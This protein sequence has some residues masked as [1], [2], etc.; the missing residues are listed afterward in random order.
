MHDDI[1]TDADLYRV[2]ASNDAIGRV[3]FLAL[4]VEAQL[5]HFLTDYFVTAERRE[6]FECLIQDR[7]TFFQKTEV[8]AGIDVLRKSSSHRRLIDCLRSIRRLRNYVA[9]NPTSRANSL[10]KLRGD[11][12]IQIWLRQFPENWS[13]AHRETTRLFAAIRR[14]KGAL[15]STMMD[16]PREIEF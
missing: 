8:F 1:S 2:L 13:H 16:D 5:D 11:R 3:L 6:S 4:R 12:N 14:V 10:P 15:K 9:H 7:L